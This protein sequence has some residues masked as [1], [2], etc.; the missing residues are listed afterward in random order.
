MAPS[1]ITPRTPLIGSPEGEDDDDGIRKTKNVVAVRRSAKSGKK[2]KVIAMIELAAS[3]TRVLSR[4]TRAIVGVLIAAAIRLLKTLVIKLVASSYHVNRFFDRIQE[5]IFHQY[6]LRDLSGTP[7]M[8]MDES[9]GRG[10]GMTG[11][12]S[13]RSIDKDKGQQKEEVID[14]DKLKKLK[15]EKISAWTMK[16]TLMKILEE[17]RE[18]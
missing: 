11:Q 2:W 9:I 3:T 10:A 18:D 13:L 7:V 6:D 8:E 1:P 17:R 15:H 5:S 14:M 16:G 4:I 12:L